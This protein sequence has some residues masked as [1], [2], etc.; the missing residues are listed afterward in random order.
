[1]ERVRE[2]DAKLKVR[3]AAGVGHLRWWCKEGSGA[4][5]HSHLPAVGQLPIFRCHCRR[6]CPWQ[7]SD[8]ALT[9][10]HRRVAELKAVSAK[11]AEEVQAKSGAACICLVHAPALGPSL[12]GA[13]PL[14]SRGGSY[15]MTLLADTHSTSCLPQRR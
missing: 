2:L 8:E 1:M 14:L 7:E 9:T 6:L 4:C 13:A 3:G 15:Q 10:A 12:V 5:L 11:L